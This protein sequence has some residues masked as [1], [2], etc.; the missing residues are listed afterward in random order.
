MEPDEM[1]ADIEITNASGVR[2]AGNEMIRSRHCVRRTI[3]GDIVAWGY[4]VKR[5][6]FDQHGL[7]CSEHWF[8]W[9][10]K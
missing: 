3:D 6:W 9:I 7:K 5:C 4:F 2:M 8:D 10:R 1:M